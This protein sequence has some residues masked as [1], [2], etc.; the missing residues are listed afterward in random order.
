M[1]DLK[2]TAPWPGHVHCC[3]RC[4]LVS[5]IAF[6]CDRLDTRLPAVTVIT[7]Q[8][9]HRNTTKRRQVDSETIVLWESN[10]LPSTSEVSVTLF[11]FSDMY[12]NT[13]KIL[14]CVDVPECCFLN[15]DRFIQYKQG[16]IYV[17]I[18]LLYGLIGYS[19]CS[20]A[21]YVCGYIL[22]WTYVAVMNANLKT[23]TWGQVYLVSTETTPLRSRTPTKQV[24]VTRNLAAL[25]LFIAPV[26]QHGVASDIS[27]RAAW[28]LVSFLST[29]SASPWSRRSSVTTRVLWHE[30]VPLGLT[31]T[32][33]VL[34]WFWKRRRR[35]SWGDVRDTSFSQSHC[36]E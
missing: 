19:L 31:M 27:H 10:N 32:N 16:F 33:P 4:F 30:E 7:R 18:K 12:L 35:I 13:K 20:C 29:P 2:W 25:Y 1:W 8:Y 22:W 24:N 6:D 34:F 14:F 5:L 28:T 17:Y 3:P 23:L 26:Y 11:L 36:D 15:V 21:V 9:C